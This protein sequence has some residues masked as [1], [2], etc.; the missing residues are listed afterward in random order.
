MPGPRVWR[1]E[2]GVALVLALMAV[3]LLSCLAAAMALAA[4]SETLVARHFSLGI[5][6]R[7]AAE[8]A[9]QRAILDLVQSPDLDAILT[10]VVRGLFIDGGPGGTRTLDD[11]SQVDLD[12]VRHRANCARDTACSPS[13]LLGNPAGDRPWG[14]NNP[15]WQLL[16]VRLC[17]ESHGVD[18][19]AFLS[20]GAGGRRSRRSRRRS[21]ARCGRDGPGR[22]PA[23]AAVR[24]HRTARGSRPR[25]SHHP[26]A[27]HRPRYTRRPGRLVAVAAL[28]CTS[29]KRSPAL[30]RIRFATITC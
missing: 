29:L 2:R 30:R 27:E 18:P 28:I 6:A 22:P 1:G 14:A 19:I 12:A 17:A 13:D 3:L 24:G 16:R 9:V 20:R 4:S 25:R 15:V 10:G 21:W 11:G 5:E 26:P 23:S 7:H 8:A